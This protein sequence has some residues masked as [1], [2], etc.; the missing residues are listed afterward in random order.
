MLYELGL[1]WG[2][3]VE[4]CYLA[5]ERDI[6]RGRRKSEPRGSSDRYLVF[7]RWCRRF[8]SSWWSPSLTDKLT[9]RADFSWQGAV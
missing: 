2:N 9:E 5:S 1:G 4:S 6:Q 3:G 8:T 7:P